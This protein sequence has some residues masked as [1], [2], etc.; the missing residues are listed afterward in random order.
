[1]YHVV[2]GYFWLVYISDNKLHRGKYVVSNIITIHI[3]LKI[4]WIHI[5]FF[6]FFFNIGL[7]LKGTD[8]LNTGGSDI[9]GSE[10]WLASILHCTGMPTSW[11][12]VDIADT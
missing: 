6:E 4:Q 7:F 3:N 8:I 2:I 5:M 9:S 10:L 1:M 11:S 12:L